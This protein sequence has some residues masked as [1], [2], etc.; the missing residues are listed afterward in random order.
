MCMSILPL[1]L[2]LG[3]KIDR[4]VICVC[5]LCLRYLT[6]QSRNSVAYNHLFSLWFFKLAIWKGFTWTVSFSA[7]FRWGRLHLYI[8]WQSVYVQSLKT[9]LREYEEKCLPICQ[10]IINISSSSFYF[11]FLSIEASVL[12]VMV[13]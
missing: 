9:F 1:V 10:A 6:N 12:L 2:Y 13:G 8:Q 3:P 7:D 5:Q 4:T 11:Y